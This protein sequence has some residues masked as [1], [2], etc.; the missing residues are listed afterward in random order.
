MAQ[1]KLNDWAGKLGK[2][3]RG[4][5]LGLKLFAAGAAAVYGVTQFNVHS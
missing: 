3:P 5:G 4:L 1:S 2:N